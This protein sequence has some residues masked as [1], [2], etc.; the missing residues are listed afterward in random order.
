MKI[1]ILTFDF[2]PHRIGGVSA[3]SM[4]MAM[5]L[6]QAGHEVDVFTKSNGDTHEHD[7]GLSFCVH[8]IRGRSWQRWGAWWMK[9]ATWRTLR[10]FDA[11]LCAHWTL[12]T[13]LGHHP[14]LCLTFHGS[15][16][17]TL[18]QPPPALKSLTSRC[19]RLWPVSLFLQD[20]LL[21]L[22]CIESGDHRTSVLP[23]PLPL[24]KLKPVPKGEHLVCVARPTERKGIDRAIKIAAATGRDL[25]LIGPSDGPPGTLALGPLSRQDTLKRIA[26]SRAILLV[27]RVGVNGRGGEGLGLCLLE[28]AS[29]GIPAIGCDTGGVIEAIGPGL[30]LP[31]PDEP[32]GK[33]INAWLDDHQRGQAAREWVGEHHGPDKAVQHLETALT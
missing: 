13:R 27:P 1:A 15:D 25:E 3:W 17:T 19:H 20:E 24:P 11:V 33:A 21:R 6:F 23:M 12:A 30:I 14:A 9:L 4:D 22:D 10:H 26:R 29:L 7:M 2:P 5:A 28:A 18:E 32:D 16:I 8:R 31:N